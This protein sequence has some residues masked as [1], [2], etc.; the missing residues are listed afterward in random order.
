MT[1]VVKS[2]IQK[3]DQKKKRNRRRE[4][5]NKTSLVREKKNRGKV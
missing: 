2:E 5:G 3:T 4:G 1:H